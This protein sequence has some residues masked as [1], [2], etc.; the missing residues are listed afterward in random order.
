MYT[1]C[2]IFTFSLRSSLF[3][4]KVGFLDDFRP[5]SDSR[6]QYVRI[7]I[8]RQSR[9]DATPDIHTYIHTHIHTYTQVNEQTELPITVPDRQVAGLGENY[10]LCDFLS[11]CG[12]LASPLVFF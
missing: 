1:R 7:R 9:T 2:I 8:L 4:P 10:K 11:I 5:N 6:T 3:W 12:P